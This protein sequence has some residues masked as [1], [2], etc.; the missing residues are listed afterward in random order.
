[1]V[2]IR[3]HVIPTR[4]CTLLLLLHDSN[5]HSLYNCDFLLLSHPWEILKVVRKNLEIKRANVTVTCFPST[6]HL[7]GTVQ[8]YLTECTKSDTRTQL[9][10]KAGEG[11]WAKSPCGACGYPYRLFKLK[12]KYGLYCIHRI[13][14][15]PF[16]FCFAEGSFFVEPA[17]FFHG[18]YIN[19]LS[20]LGCFLWGFFWDGGGIWRVSNINTKCLMHFNRRQLYA[21]RGP[22]N[23]T[24]NVLSTVQLYLTVKNCLL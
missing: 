11:G 15:P 22:A 13:L 4:D 17:P 1:M 10:P 2:L 16:F 21:F 8:L 6:V 12:N 7:L 23:S 19:C 5:V 9:T 20:G 24:V 18:K 3:Q 14:P